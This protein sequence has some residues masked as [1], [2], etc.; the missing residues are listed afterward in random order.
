VFALG[1]DSGRVIWFLVDETNAILSMGYVS[2][3]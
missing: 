2:H 3:E 1:P